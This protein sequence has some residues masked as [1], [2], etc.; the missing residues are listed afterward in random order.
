[1]HDWLGPSAP[2]D[3]DRALAELARR[4]LAGHGPAD[5][6]DLARWAGL[7]L[8]DARAGLASIA[9]EL[10]ERDDGLA[11]LRASGRRRAAVPGPRLL[12]AFDPV[13][14]GWASRE[15]IVGAHRGLITSNGLFRPFLLVDG[16]AA[17]LWR[18]QAGEVA[19][20]PFAPLGTADA[21]A[22]AAEVADVQRFLRIRVA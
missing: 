10:A 9:A 3:R 7:P 11:A 17:G 6:R 21:D 14:L 4:Y 19:L 20:Q 15:P 13:L 22:L 18:L 1:M 12:G 2:V 8:R 16:R 5:E